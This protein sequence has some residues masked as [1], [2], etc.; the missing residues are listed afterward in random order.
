MTLKKIAKMSTK[1]QIS[2]ELSG[3]YIYK[4]IYFR[5]N[6]NIKNMFT[7]MSRYQYHLLNIIYIVSLFVLE[8]IGNVLGKNVKILYKSLIRMESRGDKVDNRVLVS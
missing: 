1:S 3:L 2:N 8:S 7:N 6:I 4:I 5:W